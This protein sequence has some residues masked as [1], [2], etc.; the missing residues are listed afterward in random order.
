[1]LA[2][3]QIKVKLKEA[4]LG[5]GFADM[6]VCPAADFSEAEADRLRAWLGAGM[7]D[8]MEYL[9]RGAE[10]KISPQKFLEGAKSAVCVCASFWRESPE[11]RVA[12][13]A[14]S[15]DYH[16]V[17][18]PKLAVLAKI[19]EAEGFRAR[20]SVDSS[21]LWEK[22][23]AA[24]AGLGW[25]GKNTLL[26]R[27]ENGAWNFL[28]VVLTDAELPP[29]GPV[30]NR[31]GSCMECVKACPTGAISPRGIDARRCVSNL[32]IERRGDLTEEEKRLAAGKI[33]GCDE[34]LRACPF[35]KNVKIPPMPEFSG[36]V[37]L[38]ENPGQDEI[39]SAAKGTPM[40]RKFKKNPNKRI[41]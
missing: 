1:M 9:R 16:E 19:L 22:P 34:C 29:D 15:R 32:T 30:P 33:F 36:F 23:L 7:F 41:E 27:E 24:R 18:K 40:E 6:R 11:R 31:C 5:L 12:L 20:S 3:E 14:Q 38:P 37:S 4:A 28:G 8:K 39:L 17:I 25:I 21:P 10:A 35:G 13:Y 2:P 26:T